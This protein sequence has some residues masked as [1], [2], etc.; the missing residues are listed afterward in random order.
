MVHTHLGS[1][2]IL[3]C[4]DS[5]QRDGQ[6]EIERERGE[7]KGRGGERDRVNVS[8]HGY[9]HTTQQAL[10]TMVPRRPPN[11]YNIVQP[12]TCAYTT[13]SKVGWHR[14]ASHPTTRLSYQCPTKPSQKP[15]Q[16]GRIKAL[17]YLLQLPEAPWQLCVYT[18]CVECHSIPSRNLLSSFSLSALASA[19]S[20]SNCLILLSSWTVCI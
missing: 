2:R 17:Q 1:V 6:T 8:K 12:W 10:V 16:S 4:T 9:G 14:M 13:H 7:G 19:N 20:C 11:L 3:S 18:G 15:P 5:G